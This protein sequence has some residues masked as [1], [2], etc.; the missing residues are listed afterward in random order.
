M[1]QRA[2][3]FRHDVPNYTP[4]MIEMAWE[5]QSVNEVSRIMEQRFL[6]NFPA[7]RLQ[8]LLDK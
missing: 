6:A 8:A 3:Y 5:M 4:Q 7:R 1:T 2:D